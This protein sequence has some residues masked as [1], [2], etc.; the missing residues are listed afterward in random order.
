MAI[1]VDKNKYI[2]SHGKNPVGWGQWVFKIKGSEY[3][4]TGTF[5]QAKAKAVSKAK[6]LKTFE[7]IVMP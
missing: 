2:G 7:V 6:E 4:F 3:F 5:A 1:R